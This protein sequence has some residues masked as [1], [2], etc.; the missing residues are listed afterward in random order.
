VPPSLVPQPLQPRIDQG[1]GGC[2]LAR[3]AVAREKALQAIERL[4]ALRLTTAAELAAATF[5]EMLSYYSIPEEHWRRLRTNNTG[6]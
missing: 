4:R 3:V 6:S 5:E 1:P 2:G